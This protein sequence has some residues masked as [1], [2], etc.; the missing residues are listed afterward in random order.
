MIS[1]NCKAS[2][3]I[4]YLAHVKIALCDSSSVVFSRSIYLAIRVVK[5]RTRRRGRRRRLIDETDALTI[6]ATILSSAFRE[7]A[8][9]IRSTRARGETNSAK[10][11]PDT[12]RSCNASAKGRMP[13]D[14][15]L[16]STSSHGGAADWGGFCKMTRV[17]RGGSKSEFW[18]FSSMG[19]SHV[20]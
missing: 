8:E 20:A 12:Q 11:A 6:R 4:S 10:S 15:R 16:A 18:K 1:Q 2:M 5:G 19:W 17:C 13:S 9:E 7:S 3:Q 14:C